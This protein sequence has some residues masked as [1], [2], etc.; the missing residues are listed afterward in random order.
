MFLISSAPPEVVNLFAMDTSGDEFPLP[1]QKRSSDL[2]ITD[3][4]SLTLRCVVN[5]SNPEPIV[6]MEVGQRQLTNKDGV[7][8]SEVAKYQ[9]YPQIDRIVGLFKVTVTLSFFSICRLSV[10]LNLE[11]RAWQL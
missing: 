2:Y 8:K 4:D 7:L 5:G 1:R 6:T 11:R 9:F 3:S 10:W